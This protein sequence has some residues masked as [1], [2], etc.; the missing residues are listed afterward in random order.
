MQ[1]V[2]INCDLGEGFGRWQIGEVADARLMPLI[3]SA[4]IAAGFHAG[5]PNSI[6]HTV[7]VAVEHGVSVGAHPGYNDLQGFGRRSIM[8]TTEE[9][10][11]DLVY[12]SGA[13]GAFARRHG[14]VM[15]HIK[16]HGAI[17]MDMAKDDALSQAFVA[18]MRAADPEAF[19]YCLPGSRT[20]DAARAAGQPAV[21]E[22]FADRDYDDNG[23]IVFVRDAGHFDPEALA[24]K[25]LRACTEGKV[26]TVSGGDIDI[27]FESICVHSDTRGALAILEAL[28]ETLTGAGI[29]IAAPSQS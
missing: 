16:P 18:F 6:D 21:R 25:C 29:R 13:V 5:D 17:Y 15:R 4:N 22:F 8:G 24:R 3:T 28:H 1:S 20:Y 14:V 9:L 23:S 26:R 27:A 2:D 11:N 10:V 12:Q 7:A 19:I